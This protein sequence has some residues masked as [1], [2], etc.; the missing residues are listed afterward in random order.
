M[1]GPA[2]PSSSTAAAYA[3]PDAEDLIANQDAMHRLAGK[4]ALRRGEVMDVVDVKV[5]IFLNDKWLNSITLL[6]IKNS[7]ILRSKKS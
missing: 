5:Y 4:Y 3:Y 7:S 1:V 2:V 6:Q